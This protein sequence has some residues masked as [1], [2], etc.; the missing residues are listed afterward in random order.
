MSDTNTGEFGTEGTDT[1][2][3]EEKIEET[4]EAAEETARKSITKMLARF[5]FLTKGVLFIIIGML[6]VLVAIGFREGELA[7]TR[8]ALA[9]I[10]QAPFGKILLL[11]FVIGAG[12]YAGW[13][14]LRGI[15]DVDDHG[16]GKIGL[17]KRLIAIGL[18]LVY[19]F[20]GL[21]GLYILLGPGSAGG[22]DGSGMPETLTAVLLDFPFGVIL[23]V[24]IGLGFLAAAAGV[25][26]Q[27]LSLKFLDKFKDFDNQNASRHRLIATTGFTG[28]LARALLFGLIGYFLISAAVNYNPDKVVGLDGALRALAQQS[29]GQIILFFTAFGLICYG[30]LSILKSKFR[31]LEKG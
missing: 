9:T 12:A 17:L 4:V 11:V 10:A 26:Y 6:A 25:A 15:A 5:G 1:G 14:I 29:Y 16:N 28:F 13:N 27:A 8:G 22:G 7:G 2:E 3:F 20:I 30:F 31:D 23:V 24:L 18:G 19:A 21:V